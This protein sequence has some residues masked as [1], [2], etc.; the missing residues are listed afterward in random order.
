MLPPTRSPHPYVYYLHTELFPYAVCGRFLVFDMIGQ[1]LEDF[2]H[3]TKFSYIAQ[4]TCGPFEPLEAILCSLF[5]LL[6]VRYIAPDFHDKSLWTVDP[7][8]V[9]SLPSRILYPL[10]ESFSMS[11]HLFFIMKSSSNSCGPH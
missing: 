8:L 6:L 5:M 10:F 4:M 1:G 2:D 7:I 11:D 9:E 3:G